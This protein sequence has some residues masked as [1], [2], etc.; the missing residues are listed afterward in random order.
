MSSAV[1]TYPAGSVPPPGIAP[2]TVAVSGGPVP[3]EEIR[4]YGHSNLFY[5]WPVWAVAFLMAGLTFL[6]GHVM[7]I[8]PRGTTIE[9]GQSAPGT[10]KTRDVLVTPPGEVVPPA[11]ATNSDPSPRLRVA[12]NNNY[13]VV[14]TGV[15]LLVVTITNLTL[16]GLASV[17]AIAALVIVGLVVALF[18]WWD[19]VLFWLGGVDVRM[20]AGGYLAIGIPLFVIWAFS[21]FIYDHYTYLIVSRGQVR[22]RRE[23]GDGELAVDTAG[24]MLEKKRDDLFRH[25]LL[26]LGSG[27]LHVKTGG[28]ANLDF[29]LNNVLFVG[30]KMARIQDLIREKEVSSQAAGA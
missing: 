15:L 7:A 25:W 5:W 14:F 13:G 12:A 4:V 29:E 19:Q 28:P 27:D 30:A 3:D 1:P 17:I 22:I 18:G 20:N 2:A 16:R 11:T 26:G 6:D 10:D 23:I 24:L 8:V 21:T 9:Q